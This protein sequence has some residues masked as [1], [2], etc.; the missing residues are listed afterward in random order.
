[1]SALFVSRLY[2]TGEGSGV[3]SQPPTDC[4]IPCKH[5]PVHNE[6]LSLALCVSYD[7]DW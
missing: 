7:S 2:D 1:M 6:L 4:G 3:E 5:R